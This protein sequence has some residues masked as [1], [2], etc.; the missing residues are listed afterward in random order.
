MIISPIVRFMTSS[1]LDLRRPFVLATASPDRRKLVA[2]T[3][4]SF[5]PDAVDIDEAPLPGEGLSDYVSRLAQA[6][7][8]A[9]IPPSLE[10]IIVAVDTAIGLGEEIIG[11]PADEANAREILARLSGKTHEV[12]SAIALSDIA[13]GALEVEITRTEVT[14]DKLSEQTIRWYLATGE[15]K[16]R[17]GAYAIQGKGAALIAGVRGCLTN[18]IGISIPTLLRMLQ[19]AAS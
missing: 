8:R 18:V 11:K 17:A 2:D 4:L 3:G 13:H 7:A 9:A 5:I 6:K 15:W 16:G 19:S 10:A 14:F 12:A 1:I